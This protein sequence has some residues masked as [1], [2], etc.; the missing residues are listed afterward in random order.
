MSFW[1]VYVCV[2]AHTHVF[3]CQE[4]TALLTHHLKQP[5][6]KIYSS[7]PSGF[8]R[9][10]DARATVHVCFS[11]TRPQVECNDLN[12]LGKVICLPSHVIPLSQQKRCIQKTKNKKNYV[13]SVDLVIIQKKIKHSY[14][15]PYTI[16]LS[17][18]QEQVVNAGIKEC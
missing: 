11:T 12:T 13:P 10:H 6:T 17:M 14:S 15:L 16:H 18:S 7:S 1:C 2:C 5:K 4:E 9:L 8:D 3:V